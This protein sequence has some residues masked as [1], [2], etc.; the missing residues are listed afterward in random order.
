MGK[1]YRENVVSPTVEFGTI[2][3][4]TELWYLGLT[5]MSGL[6]LKW[7]YE[8]AKARFFGSLN[9]ILGRL[10]NSP[11]ET[12]GLSLTSSNCVPIPNF[13]I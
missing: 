5:F 9:S 3:F 11:P 2:M 8:K 7:D 10:G 4:S 1:R 12:L 13:E 6:S